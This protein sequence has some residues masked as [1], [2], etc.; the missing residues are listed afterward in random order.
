MIK[1]YLTLFKNMGKDGEVIWYHI[2]YLYSNH[3]TIMK[4][5]LCWV[6]KSSSRVIFFKKPYILSL[7]QQEKTFIFKKSDSFWKYH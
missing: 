4:N 2:L 3:A 1:P 5:V 7:C 6:F